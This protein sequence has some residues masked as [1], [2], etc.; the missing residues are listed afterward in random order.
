MVCTF[1][2]PSTVKAPTSTLNKLATFI[3]PSGRVKLIP[4]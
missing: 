2:T 1:K 3:V 4:Q